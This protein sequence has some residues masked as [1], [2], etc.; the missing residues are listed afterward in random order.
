MSV[1]SPLMAP[2]V[3]GGGV[4]RA[5][6][7]LEGRSAGNG[8]VTGIKA[9]GIALQFARPADLQGA[10]A[11]RGVTRCRCSPRRGSGCCLMHQP[12]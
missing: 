8:D 12:W 10:A 6:A 1:P 11:D 7:V 2:S 5:A 9:C 4:A 3:A